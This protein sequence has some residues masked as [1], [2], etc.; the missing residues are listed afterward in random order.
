VPG[1]T[2]A[3]VGLACYEPLPIQ[4]EVSDAALTSDAGLLPV[5]QF[6]KRLGLTRQF[7]EALEDPRDPDRTEHPFLEMVRSRL[8]HPG[9]LRGPE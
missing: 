9:R 8:R 7:A 3:W 2:A 6:D 1:A 5:R 4:V